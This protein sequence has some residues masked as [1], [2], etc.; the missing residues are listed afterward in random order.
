MQL[1]EVIH[2]NK[3]LLLV[4]EYL[5]YDLKKFMTKVGR[6]KGIAPE[7]VKVL[8]ILMHRVSPT[9]CCRGSATAI[10]KRSSIVTSSPRTC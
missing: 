5:E 4:F 7:L 10:R 2:S 6:E 1:K 3:K 9:N 8:L